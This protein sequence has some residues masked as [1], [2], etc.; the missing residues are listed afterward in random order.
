MDLVVRMRE[1]LDVSFLEKMRFEPG[2]RIFRN[3]DP[4]NEGPELGI[5][6]GR[7]SV[8]GPDP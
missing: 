8:T 1:P 2:V 3:R 6:Q 7:E 4:R 5:V